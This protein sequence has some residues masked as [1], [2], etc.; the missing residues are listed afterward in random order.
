MYIEY[1]IGRVGTIMTKP[2]PNSGQRLDVKTYLELDRLT[3]K[4]SL[5]MSRSF[6]R[7]VWCGVGWVSKWIS[8][9]AHML[10]INKCM[11]LIHVVEFKV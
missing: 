7:V 1:T 8:W 10:L 5:N 3:T 6:W 4:L 9:S 2:K 11:N